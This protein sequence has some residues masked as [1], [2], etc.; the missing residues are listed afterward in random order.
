MPRVTKH[1]FPLETHYI[2]VLDLLAERCNSTTGPKMDTFLIFEGQEGTGK[3]TLSIATGYYIA[4]KTGRSFNHENV[5]FDVE[6]MLEFASNTEKQIII[7]DE[8]ALQ[9]LSTNSRNRI[10]MMF[11]QFMM[12]ARKKRHFIMINLTY[13]NRFDNYILDRCNG[14]V[15][16]TRKP[17]KNQSRFA[18]F[19]QSKARRLFADYFTKK[20]KLYNK[21]QSRYI[22]G[23]F[24]DILNPKYKYNVLGDFDLDYYENAKDEAIKKVTPEEQQKVN[25]KEIKLKWGIYNLMKKTDNT[26]AVIAEHLQVDPARISEWGKLHEKYPI[27]VSK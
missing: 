6:K 3:T 17:G 25:M 27:L 21:Y 8:P 19:K 14:M 7:F 24:P 23:T 4:E 10:S 13:F 5:F 18:Y 1:Q 20:K 15:R 12:M 2:N 16:V 26:R 9:M 11:K 22:R